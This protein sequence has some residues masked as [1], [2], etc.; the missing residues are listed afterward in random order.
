MN[1][2]KQLQRK[3]GTRNVYLK[4]NSQDNFTLRKIVLAIF[5]Q[6]T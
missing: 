5:T 4:I 6:L 1:P 3:T 2:I